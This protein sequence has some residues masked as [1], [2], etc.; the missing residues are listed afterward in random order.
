VSFFSDRAVQGVTCGETY[1]YGQ[2]TPAYYWVRTEKCSDGKIVNK[3]F[4]DTRIA[5]DEDGRVI[6]PMRQRSWSA[7]GG[8]TLRVMNPGTGQVISKTTDEKAQ[9][10]ALEQQ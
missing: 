1:Q 4:F 8:L 6:G 10:P 2:N 9:E 7:T 3:G 5:L